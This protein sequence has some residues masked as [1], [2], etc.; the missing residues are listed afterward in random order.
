[1]KEKLKSKRHSDRDDLV[2][3]YPWGDMGQII[4]LL[5]FLVIWIADSFI[6]KYSTSL[7]AA[8]PNFIKIPLVLFFLISS[9]YFARS[10][11][12]IAFGEVPKQPTV[13]NVG[14]F[15]VVRHPI[16]LGSI[17]FYL[18]PICVTFSLLSLLV[19]SVIVFFYHGIALYEEKLLLQQFG[20]DYENYQRDV[21]MWLPKISAAKQQSRQNS[22][23]GIQP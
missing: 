21:P 22:I 13:I 8:V 6:F 12:R 14:V 11:L 1:M 20:S 7:A 16:Y 15:G 2:G 3:E 19:W 5:L 18:A 4:F 23:E 10:G 9:G 17:L